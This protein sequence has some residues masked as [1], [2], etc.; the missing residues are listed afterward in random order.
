MQN[1]IFV[2]MKASSEESCR[3]GGKS[4]L[5]GYQG[6]IFLKIGWLYS[7]K[8]LWMLWWLIW[9]VEGEEK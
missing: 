9:W 4:R 5:L 2:A 6:I 3:V 8:N 1:Y 7:E